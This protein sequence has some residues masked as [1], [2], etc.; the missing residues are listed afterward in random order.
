MKRLLTASVL[1]IAGTVGSVLLST[2]ETPALAT[3]L[4]AGGSILWWV[5]W[6][7]LLLMMGVWYGI[8]LGRNCKI[9]TQFYKI[10]I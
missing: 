10:M 5:F 3:L 8:T 2:I 1:G 9:M 7:G 6:E 4:L